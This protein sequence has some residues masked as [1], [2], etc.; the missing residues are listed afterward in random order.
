MEINVFIHPFFC[1]LPI[2]HVLLASST[3]VLLELHVA[4]VVCWPQQ[5]IFCRHFRWTSLALPWHGIWLGI[6]KTLATWP[7]VAANKWVNKEDF[8]L[9]WCDLVLQQSWEGPS[10]E[11]CGKWKRQEKKWRA[12]I[13]M[14]CVFHQWTYHTVHC[15]KNVWACMW[16]THQLKVQENHHPILPSNLVCFHSDFSLI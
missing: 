15:V 2:H 14:T 16:R 10:T 11:Q 8:T 1:E 6:K 3:R 9:G 5:N 7:T 12:L 4:T 13:S